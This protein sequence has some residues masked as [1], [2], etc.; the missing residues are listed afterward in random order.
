[1]RWGAPAASQIATGT[2]SVRAAPARTTGKG[3]PVAAYLTVSLS[4]SLFM[5]WY[6][7]RM[8]LKER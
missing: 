1:M 3:R 4:I 2:P 6:D 7:R 5:H 8:A